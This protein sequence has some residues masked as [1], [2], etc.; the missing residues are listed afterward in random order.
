MNDKAE[1]LLLMTMKKVLRDSHGPDSYIGVMGVGRVKEGYYLKGPWSTF[2]SSEKDSPGVHA[3]HFIKNALTPSLGPLPPD[4]GKPH[5]IVLITFPSFITNVSISE[6]KKFL[7]D[8]SIMI[9]S[10]D[11]PWCELTVWR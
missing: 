11:L 3:R 4:K 5:K 7:N 2:I 1:D 9:K 6:Q 8:W 10:F